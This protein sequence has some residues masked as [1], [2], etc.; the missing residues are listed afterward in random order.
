MRACQPF[1]KT[2]HENCEGVPSQY[3]SK[4]LGEAR[5]GEWIPQRA[6]QSVNELTETVETVRRPRKKEVA[7]DERT[8]DVS[9]RMRHRS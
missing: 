1:S 7:P 2:R 3:P 8:E 6:P 9:P 5:Y 4:Q